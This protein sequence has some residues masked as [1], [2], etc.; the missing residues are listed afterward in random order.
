[1]AAVG[2][3]GGGVREVE[4]SQLLG[5]RWDLPS[6]GKGQSMSGHGVWAKDPDEITTVF[7]SLGCFAFGHFA[8]GVVKGGYL[9]PVPTWKVILLH[10]H[11]LTSP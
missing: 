11:H 6:H 4:G 7:F 8:P 2:G 5:G 1:M 10:D 9:Y 3:Q